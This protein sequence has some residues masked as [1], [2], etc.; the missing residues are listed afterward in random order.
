[1]HATKTGF[2]LEAFATAMGRCDG[3][4]STSPIAVAIQ[5]GSTS[6]LEFIISLD[7]RERML[8]ARELGWNAPLATFLHG[9]D[10]FGAA[11]GCD[12]AKL[13]LM[14][15]DARTMLAA[16]KIGYPD[17]LA[18]C[19]RGWFRAASGRLATQQQ[20]LEEHSLTTPPVMTPYELLIT[21]PIVALVVR[22]HMSTHRPA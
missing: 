6:C 17:R 15:P 20:L 18:D 5:N 8:I 3:A 4:P 16:L 1:V 19:G 12:V 2:C 10:S 9:L 14:C 21:D 13:C 22:S 7:L 11:V